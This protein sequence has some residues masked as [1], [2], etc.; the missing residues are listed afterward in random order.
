M[1]LFTPLKRLFFA[2]FF[3]FSYTCVNASD[4]V[5]DGCFGCEGDN[6]TKGFAIDYG[7]TKIGYLAF[8]NDDT[9]QYMYLQMSED[10]VDTTFGSNA[11]ANYGG[12]GRTFEK[13]ISS[14][15]LGK[16]GTPLT[17]YPNSNN[18]DK[19]E[20]IVDLMSCK[21]NYGDIKK[22]DKDKKCKGY[23]VNNEYESSGYTKTGYVKAEGEIES[24]TPSSYF[25]ASVGGVDNI[26]TSMDY[27]VQNVRNGVGGIFDTSKSYQS[28]DNGA[29]DYESNWLMYIGY[30]FKFTTKLFNLAALA[31]SADGSSISDGVTTM[32]LPNSHASPSLTGSNSATTTVTDCPVGQSCTPPPITEVPEP[33][34]MLI[35]GLALMG[36][37]T[38]RRQNKLT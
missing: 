5:V 17:F 22:K 25:G 34:T 3:I 1:K 7:L 11:N 20:I 33:S 9:N 37:L 4:F 16:D 14:D 13:I 26:A 35:F 6:Y 18:S 2:L 32:L 8:G 10:F 31:V 38:S 23:D 21:D 27:N 29:A 15:G 24:G 28:I 19:T 30:E 12:G 36:M